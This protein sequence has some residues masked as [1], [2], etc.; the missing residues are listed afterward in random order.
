MVPTKADG[1]LGIELNVGARY[2]TEDGFF[3][4]LQYGYLFPLG[5][6]AYFGSDGN[7]IT[8]DNPQALRAVVGIRY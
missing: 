3:G 8:L 1:N 4:Q 2:E 5:G 6:L 7:P